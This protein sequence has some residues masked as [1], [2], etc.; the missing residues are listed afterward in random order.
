MFTGLAKFIWE[1]KGEARKGAKRMVHYGPRPVRFARGSC[2]N[3]H[4][5]CGFTRFRPGEPVQSR[6][7]A[8]P[9]PRGRHLEAVGPAGG[10]ARARL[11]GRPR[12]PVRTHPRLSRCCRDSLSRVDFEQ[13]QR[14]EVRDRPGLRVTRG[15]CR[16]N[17]QW[18]VDPWERG[19]TGV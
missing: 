6:F 2:F 15:W 13:Q 3:G 5:I 17:G 18:E 19:V 7:V 8:H 4:S 14:R 1:R 16:R 10:L 9:T 12:L 11:S